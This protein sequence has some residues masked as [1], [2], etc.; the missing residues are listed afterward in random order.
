[1]ESKMQRTSE[2]MTLLSRMYGVIIPD[3]IPPETDWKALSEE[4]KYRHVVALITANHGRRI[5]AGQ[6]GVILQVRPVG[7]EIE[8]R[9]SIVGF[10]RRKKI[11]LPNPGYKR[12][13]RPVP[14]EF[15]QVQRRYSSRD[16]KDERDEKLESLIYGRWKPLGDERPF[17]QDPLEVQKKILIQKYALERAGKIRIVQGRT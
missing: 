17:L 14:R 7:E 4:E 9:N 2:Q 15:K 11:E 12:S 10:C 16:K 3:S 6:I 1:M 13:P 5:T 8:A